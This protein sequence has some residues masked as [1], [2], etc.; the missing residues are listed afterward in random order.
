MRTVL[1]ALALLAQIACTRTDSA[2]VS[3]KNTVAGEWEGVLAPP[4]RDGE[5]FELIIEIDPGNTLRGSLA[6]DLDH[7]PIAGRY[8]PDEDRITFT[9]DFDDPDLIEIDLRLVDDQLKGT[10]RKG[11]MEIEISATRMAAKPQFYHDKGFALPK[12]RPVNVETTVL[13]ENLARR[14]NKIVEEAMDRQLAVGVSTAVILH[15]KIADVRHF[16]WEDVADRVAASGETMYRWASVAKP[17]TGV[18]AMQLVE[19]GKLDLQRDVREYVP[20]FPE[21][22]YTV[23]TEGLLTHTAGIVHYSNGDVIATERQYYVEHPAADR[24]L[25]LDMFKESPLIAEPGTTYSYSSHGYVLLGAV[26]ERAGGAK[27]LDQVKA[28][29]LSPLSMESMQPDYDWIDIEHRATG[30]RG[31]RIGLVSR[32]TDEEVSWKLPAGGWIST[33]HDLARFATGLL[34]D[35]LMRPESKAAMFTE[36]SLTDGSGIGYGYGIGV[37]ELHGLKV[38]AHSGQQSAAASYLLICPSRNVGVVVMSNTK[39]F[40]ATRL[41]Q[42][43]FAELIRD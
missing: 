35:R 34:S 36:R 43:I 19:Q 25:S 20:E 15:G 22:E 24:V 18:A 30:Y 10:I 1:I 42:L 14:L 27:F 32:G 5:R 3:T 26:I 7:S 9:T 13:A 4:D 41:G 39:N 11:E 6:V 29:V 21:K 31:S 38:Y 2:T 12:D 28:R 33:T 37:L 16:G 23:T 8:V 17:L 40:E